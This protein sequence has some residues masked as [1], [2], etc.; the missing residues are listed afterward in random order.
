ML[1]IEDGGES[2]ECFESVL[3]LHMEDLDKPSLR[4]L[5]DAYESKGNLLEALKETIKEHRKPLHHG[6][7]AEALKMML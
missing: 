4:A 7:G 5:I 3:I 6:A 2:L 1:N